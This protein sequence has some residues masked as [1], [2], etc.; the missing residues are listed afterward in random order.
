MSPQDRLFLAGQYLLPH[1]L[2]TGVFGLAAECRYPAYKNWMIDR[3]IR[4]YGVDM[5]ESA[6]QDSHAFEH[7]NAFF[8]RALKPGARPLDATLRSRSTLATLWKVLA[9]PMK[10]LAG[11][12]GCCW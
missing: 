12:S 7:F 4:K 9:R 11:R 5:S 3:F 1:R 10:G 2:V 8:T 6:I